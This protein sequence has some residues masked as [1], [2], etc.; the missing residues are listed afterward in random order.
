MESKLIPP[1]SPL[2]D[3]PEAFELLPPDLQ[4]RILQ[5]ILKNLYPIKSFNTGRSSYNIKDLVILDGDEH[6][7]YLTNGEFKGAMLRAGYK[8]QDP[9]KKNW[10][11]NVSKRSPAFI[12]KG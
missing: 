2:Q 9:T 4:K 7:T 12:K 10:V 1:A 11:F 8:V 3:S 5:W 6:K